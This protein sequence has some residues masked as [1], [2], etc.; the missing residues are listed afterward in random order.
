MSNELPIINRS[1]IPEPCPIAWD[2]M[3]GNEK[4]RHCSQC[5]KSVYHLSYMTPAEANRV[6]EEHDGNLCI[7]GIFR[8]SD[9]QLVTKPMRRQR[10]SHL[11]R[12]AVAMLIGLPPAHNPVR[13]RRAETERKNRRVGQTK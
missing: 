11:F 10:L 3:T 6:I 7:H 13:L 1:N 12:R 9:G 2:D 4:T 8:V 5:E